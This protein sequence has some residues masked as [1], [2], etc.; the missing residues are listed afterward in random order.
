MVTKDFGFVLKRYNFRETSVITS[1]YT[2]KFG[3]ITGIL[4]G[5]YTQKKEFASH[6]DNLSLNEIVFYPK[7]S[8]VWLVSFADL[9]CDYGYLRSD[10]SRANVAS[11]FLN[12]IDKTMQPL[13]KNLEVFQLL[14]DSLFSLKEENAKKALYVF[15]IKFLTLSGFKPE[16]GKCLVCH[17]PANEETLFSVSRGG[18]VCKKCAPTDQDTRKIG[19]DTIASLFY[20][21]NN[22]FSLALRIKPAAECEK[23]MVYLLREFLCCHLDIDISPKLS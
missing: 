21:Q 18:L 5:F 19:A 6:L 20:I 10:I 11:I 13:D 1:F 17:K 2:Q 9:V 4:K 23:E 8:D 3:K 12:L 22:D 16:F 7:K 15:L 14:R